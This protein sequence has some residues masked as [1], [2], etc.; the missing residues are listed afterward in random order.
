MESVS[1]WLEVNY[2]FTHPLKCDSQLAQGSQ[3]EGIVA[4]TRR[5]IHA[6]QNGLERLDE[7]RSD[8]NFNRA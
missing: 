7:T 6:T 5:D 2:P 3:L 8:F 1:Y 4:S